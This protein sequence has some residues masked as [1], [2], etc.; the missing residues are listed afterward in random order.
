MGTYPAG[1]KERNP[2]LLT[3][4]WLEQKMP[5]VAACDYE[6]QLPFSG[7]YKSSGLPWPASESVGR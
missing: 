1:G 6:E 4:L 2:C 7:G 5:A 3:W